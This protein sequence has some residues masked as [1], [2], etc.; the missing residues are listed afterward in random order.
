MTMPAIIIVTMPLLCHYMDAIEQP[1]T[2]QGKVARGEIIRLYPSTRE[3]I[4]A[5]FSG[6]ERVFVIDSDVK[7]VLD[8]KPAKLSDLKEFSFVTIQ[9]DDATP[10]PIARQITGMGR[11]LFSKQMGKKNEDH[12]NIAASMK[13]FYATNRERN[14]DRSSWGTYLIHFSWCLGSLL[15]TMALM[16]IARLRNKPMLNWLTLILWMSTAVLTYRAVDLKINQTGGNLPLE[17]LYGNDRGKGIEYGSC[18]VSIPREHKLGK[19]ES[20]SILRL[21]FQFDPGKHVM[22]Q[23]IDHLLQE[24][25][26]AE[27]NG[28]LSRSIRKEALVFIHGYNV[29]FS[30][31]ARR[32]AQLAYDLEFDGPALFFSWPSQAGLFEYTID[33]SNVEWSSQD[34][35]DFLHLIASKTGARCLHVVAHSMGNRALTAA[36]VE[37]SRKQDHRPEKY[38][39]VILA[40]PDIDADTFQRRLFPSIQK[41]ARHFTLYASSNDNALEASKK[42]HGYPRAGDSGDLLVLLPG[43]DTID[44]SI[45]DTSLLG[46]SYY[47]DNKSII[48]DLHH[49]IDRGEPPQNR[50]WLSEA[51]RKSLKYWLFRVLPRLDQDDEEMF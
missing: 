31:A 33:E 36:F 38:R 44:V 7:I 34:V 42:V 45:V 35:A 10:L 24:S 15:A 26:L 46:H 13:V 28:V 5:D 16:Y 47:G 4:L 51:Q 39:E 29:S 14:Q 3:I 25:F 37:L 11:V 19:V 41:L 18:T 12:E 49:L 48:T 20:P 43:L 21:E 40:A 22:L 2:P 9:Y 27:F 50:P 1:S 32:T 23:N 30:D 6:K 17:K 8:N